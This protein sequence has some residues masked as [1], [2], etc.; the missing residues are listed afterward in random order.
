[1][2]N[3][4]SIE[5]TVSTVVKAA[6]SIIQNMEMGSRLTTK[7]FVT[8]IV[9]ETDVPVAIATG[10]TALV[11]KNCDGVFQRSGRGG[12]I[13]RVEPKM[14]NENKISAIA[15]ALGSSN[16]SQKDEEYKDSMDD[17]EEYFD[18]NEAKEDLS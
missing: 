14:S 18:S 12:G 6:E 9:G 11:V 1:M 3:E 2:I 17:D 5:E 10:L 8:R 7:E 13:F 16:S 4:K 15:S